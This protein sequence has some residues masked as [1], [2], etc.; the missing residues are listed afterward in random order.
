VKGRSEI[1]TLVSA[2]LL[3]YCARI[4]QDIDR[5]M[6]GYELIKQLHKVTE[7]EPEA[8]YFH[9]LQQAF[10]ALDD[11]GIG[12]DL[13]RLWFSAQL[14]RLS[15]YT[16]NLQTGPDGARLTAGQT[17]EFSFDDSAFIERPDAPYDADAIK[18]LRLTFSGN[19]PH[20]L[21][22]V[23]GSAQLTEYCLPLVTNLRQLHLR[24]G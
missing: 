11:P 21:S 10:T 18:F 19:R 24:L 20:A 8:D 14:L 3:T 2:R 16:P 15:G 17:Y 6:L 1:G 23:R 7:D 12:L 13:I 4:V 9:L 5:T 22:K